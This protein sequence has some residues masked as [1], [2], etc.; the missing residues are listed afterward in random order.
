MHSEYLKVWNYFDV[1]AFVLHV[2]NRLRNTVLQ[3]IWSCQ[4]L[5]LCSIT[6]LSNQVDELYA[7]TNNH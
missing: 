6:L 5:F 3:K 2:A 1:T 7:P 4:T